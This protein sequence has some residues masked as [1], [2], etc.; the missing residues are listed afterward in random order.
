MNFEERMDELKENIQNF[1]REQTNTEAN[2]QQ[3]FKNEVGDK[4]P[5]CEL[6][7]LEVLVSTYE[8]TCVIWCPNNGCGMSTPMC[9]TFRE[10]YTYLKAMLET[11]KK[12]D[13]ETKHNEQRPNE[14]VQD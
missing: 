5:W 10:A 3:E 11:K 2:L 7:P 9:K 4:C 13:Q 6:G 8:N 1:S 12:L 14:N